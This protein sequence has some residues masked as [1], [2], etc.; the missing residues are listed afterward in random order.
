MDG[1]EV[2]PRMFPDPA[3]LPAYALVCS[4][5]FLFLTQPTVALA[6]AAEGGDF[7]NVIGMGVGVTPDYSGASSRSVAVA[8]LF[9]YKFKTSERSV[10]VLGPVASFNIVDNRAFNAGPTLRYRPGRT[11]ADDPVIAQLHEV[12][13]TV[14]AGF[15]VS[16]GWIG[17]PEW[18]W[19][20]R[21]WASGFT[22]LGDEGGNSASVT[23]NVLV[24]V[25]RRTLL[26]VGA[27]VNYASADSLIAD[28]G[29]TQADSI[30]SGLAP[31]RPSGG[32]S[33]RDLWVGATFLATESWV[34]GA[35]VYWQQLS[36]QAAD[37]PI[38]IE[39]GRKE[40][41]SAGVGLAYIWN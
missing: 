3:K 32:T 16:Y 19:R 37:S 11:D 17:E 27:A 15:F 23:G 35:G 29:V 36:G 28:Y 25:S 7:P 6:Q 26:A 20:V 21:V 38:V 2:W 24:P 8:P 10:T 22:S 13:A 39:R 14:D 18:P 12:D 9:N 1:R 4:A 40:Q 30:R 31:F 41:L 33:S 5:I 34:V